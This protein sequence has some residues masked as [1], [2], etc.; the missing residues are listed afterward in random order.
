MATAANETARA[1][2]AMAAS[3]NTTARATIVV[4][5]ITALTFVGTTIIG[6]LSVQNARRLAQA[7][8]RAYVGADL[9]Q[10]DKQSS[11]LVSVR[12]VNLGKTPAYRVA[13]R[14]SV[15]WRPHK[16]TAAS[17]DRNGLEK[18]S[19]RFPLAAG[20]TFLTTP[21]PQ[22]LSQGELQ[23]ILSGKS[24]LSAY[25]VIEYTDRF[26]SQ[27]TTRYCFSYDSVQGDFVVCDENLNT[28]D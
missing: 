20:M 26:G 15:Q 6:L 16:V 27:H 17:F 7:E 1:T 25:G 18:E 21:E 24:P 13:N 10:W 3:A 9:V 5:L 28:A 8:L 12:G 2:I 23:A 11:L 14:A 22:E 19:R 4:A